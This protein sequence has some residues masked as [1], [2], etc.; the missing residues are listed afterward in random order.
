MKN[1][2]ISLI[3]L[4]FSSV[5]FGQETPDTTRFSIGTSKVIIINPKGSEVQIASDTMNAEP[6]EEELSAIEAHWSGIDFGPTLL[7]NQDMKAN[8]PNNSQWENDPAK[9]FSWSW[10]IAE[11]KF[12]I[13]KNQI[14]ITT[15]L[16][17]NWTQIGLKQYVL[18]NTPDSLFA[19]TDSVNV[20]RRNKLRA[21]Y[22][23]APLLIEFCGNESGEDGFYLAAGLIGGV[24]IGSSVKT[25]TEGDSK[26]KQKTKG[27]YGLEAF[28]LDAALRMGFDDWG[29]YVNY[30]LI[31][32][33]DTDKTV[34]VHPLTFGV[35]LSF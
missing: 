23:T 11:H 24:R 32:M 8:F 9:S 26:T 20:F 25:V 1:V 12:S 31:P 27:T 3:T 28:R 2:N 29:V 35:S 7:L 21:I 6:D 18:Q 17:L 33:F 15:G 16:G 4:F 5:L 10:N 30:N 14:G 19:I 34:A 13:Y 22:L